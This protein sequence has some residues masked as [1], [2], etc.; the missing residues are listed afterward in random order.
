MVNTQR[1][2][3][4][5]AD[6]N[7]CAWYES[8]P[9]RM[10]AKLLRGIEQFDIAVVGAGYTG[11][12]AARRLGEL[13]PHKRI[14]L[15]EAQEVGIGAAGRSSGFAIDLA[16]DMRSKSFVD[17]LEE[18]SRQTRINRAGLAYLKE[19]VLNS[20][21][22]SSDW[23]EL[24][25]IHAAATLAGE[26]KLQGFSK[27]L[28]SLKEPYHWL[29]ADEMCSITGS[30]YYRRG[31]HTPGAVLVQPAAMVQHLADSLP[32]NVTLYEN[33]PVKEV[34]YN[35]PI[36]LR[37]DKG[38]VR[39]SQ[40]ILANNGYAQY[41]GF[42][43]HHLIPFMTYGS[44]TRVLTDEE[45]KRLGGDNSWGII[46]A[47]A[48]GSSL[49]KT[50]DNRLLV[51]HTYSYADQFR[52][53]PRML[54][55]MHDEHRQSFERRFPMLSNVDFEYTWGGA[56]CLSRNG[57]PVFGQLQ[58]NIYGAFCMNGVGITK[59][60]I[61]GKLIAEH[62]AGQRSELGDL[63]LSYPR[64]NLVPPGFILKLGV[65]LDLARRSIGV[66]LEK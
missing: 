23:E 63:L 47:D 32:D 48:F 34:L 52:A 28:D 26:A 31:I 36:C 40:L 57:A 62:L 41:L 9:K 35:Q 16:H 30:D 39:A 22:D 4:L 51:R 24:G 43:Q 1:V 50:L 18:T 65:T 38:E 37:S 8:L 13:L 42:Y 7:R 59:G 6:D 10:S 60:T 46:P 5:P 11:L 17:G 55:R 58:E 64:P 14:A 19:G 12:A 2:R 15:L 21:Y 56:L 61:M 66:G 20:D 53:S 49:R 45:L 27:V 29:S 54:K 33:S 44:M 25:K 3:L